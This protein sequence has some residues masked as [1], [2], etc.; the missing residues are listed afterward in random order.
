MYR[1]FV[2]FKGSVGLALAFVS[3]LTRFFVKVATMIVGY[4]ELTFFENCIII[5]EY[6]LDKTIMKSKSVGVWNAFSANRTGSCRLDEKTYRLAV[7]ALHPA[8]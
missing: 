8:S 7:H 2:N 6:V 5:K 3:H 4:A 1:R